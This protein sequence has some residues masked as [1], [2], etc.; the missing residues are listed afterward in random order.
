MGLQR[1]EFYAYVSMEP[2]LHPNAPYRTAGEG[3]GPW[4]RRLYYS[5]IVPSFG[6]L[7]LPVPCERIM[8]C[9]HAESDGKVL[10]SRLCSYQR[11][12]LD[13]SV[14]H[15]HPV[16]CWSTNCGVYGPIKIW[17]CRL[18]ID[19]IHHYTRSAHGTILKGLTVCD[20]SSGI[21]LRAT[22]TTIS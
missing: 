20:A 14:D 21:P 2:H 9:S 7:S 4:E 1:L 18:Q 10:G 11:M 17:S 22:T 5:P 15:N 16:P 12:N 13:N 3:C 6:T 19:L 8:L